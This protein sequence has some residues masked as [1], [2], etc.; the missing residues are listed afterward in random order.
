MTFI[1]I[2]SA[3]HNETVWISMMSY[4]GWLLLKA[5]PFKLIWMTAVGEET[6]TQQEDNNTRDKHAVV[7]IKH[8][9]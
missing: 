5:I 2:Y 6:P 9:Q 7:V 4:K 3:R 8:K 1:H